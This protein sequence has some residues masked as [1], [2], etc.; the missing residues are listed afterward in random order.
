M[1]EYQWC[2]AGSRLA[3]LPLG[4]ANL[5]TA[6]DAGGGATELGCQHRWEVTVTIK[7]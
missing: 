1:E 5:L 6:L 7:H 4:M 3:V 2:L